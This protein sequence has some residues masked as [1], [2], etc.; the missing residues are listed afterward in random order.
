MANGLELFYIYSSPEAAL[1]Y[2]IPTSFAQRQNVIMS[3]QRIFDDILNVKNDA[4]FHDFVTLYS[5]SQARF[6][7]QQ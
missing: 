6:V 2:E 1:K 4:P 5:T 7:A 3:Q